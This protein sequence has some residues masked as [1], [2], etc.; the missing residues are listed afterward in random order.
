ML[1][2][3]SLFVLGIVVLLLAVIVTRPSEYRVERASTMTAPPTVIFDF[4]NDFHRWSSW[5]PWEKLDPAMTRTYDGSSAGSGAI[6]SWSGNDKVGA[7]RMT[8]TDSKPGERIVIKLEFFK[9]WEATSTTTFTF[10]GQGDTTK[11]VWTM[12]GANDLKGKAFTLFM[13][14]DDMVGRDLEKG[15]SELKSQS[16]TVARERAAAMAAAAVAP[17]PAAPAVPPAGVP[18]DPVKPDAPGAK[19]TPPT[20]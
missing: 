11:V 9:P 13:N 1:R 8:I 19:P 4:V 5:S 2:K 18:A 15:L 17:P 14:M 7:G 16:E 6:Y 12:D 20:P 3:A 10:T